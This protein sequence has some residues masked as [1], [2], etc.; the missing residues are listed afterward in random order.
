E[1]RRHRVEGLVYG[2]DALARGGIR[3]LRNDISDG[4]QEPAPPTSSRHSLV[5]AAD[6]DSR[7]PRAKAG[8]IVEARERSRRVDE[9]FLDDVL[10][11]RIAPHQS[12]DH[13][14]YVPRMTAIERGERPLI[15]RDRLRDECRI[16]G[17]DL[18]EGAGGAIDPTQHGFKRE[19]S[20]THP[21]GS[22]NF[23]PNEKTERSC[24]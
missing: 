20:T 11:L 24:R 21:A 22:R 6:D 2:V 14:R 23:V 8:R 19:R 9:A 18:V 4:A 15:S 17:G 12:V 1:P 10:E 5:H 16:V 13:P 3:D 7:E